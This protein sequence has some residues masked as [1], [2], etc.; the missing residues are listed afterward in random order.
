MEKLISFL[1]WLDCKMNK[2]VHKQWTGMGGYW[3]AYGKI[4]KE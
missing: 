4:Y 3:I 2:N 1:V